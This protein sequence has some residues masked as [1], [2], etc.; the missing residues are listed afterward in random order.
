[1]QKADFL[2][3][4]LVANPK[5]FCRNALSPIMLLQLC[6]LSS[7]LLRVCLREHRVYIFYYIYRQKFG[8]NPIKGLNKIFTKSK[9]IDIGR[10]VFHSVW[11][12][13][14]VHTYRAKFFPISDANFLERLPH[15]TQKSRISFLGED[16]ANPEDKSNAFIYIN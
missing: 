1:M 13:E 2:H 10:R 4:L 14:V 16:K 12:P 15:S 8:K 11:Y 7:L 5:K 3:F 9:P 6:H